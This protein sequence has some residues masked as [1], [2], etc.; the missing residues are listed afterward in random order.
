MKFPS[1]IFASAAA[2]WATAAPVSA[3]TAPE[4]NPSQQTVENLR[5]A[6]QRALGAMLQGGDYNTALHTI[7]DHLKEATRSGDLL[8]Q[9]GAARGGRAR[10]ECRVGH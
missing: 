4:A 8:A 1:L 5:E 2:L 9:A 10:G 6:G 7:E 3:Q